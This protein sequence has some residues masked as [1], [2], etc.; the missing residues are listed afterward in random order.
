MRNEMPR[1]LDGN[2][3]ASKLHRASAM[4]AFELV[5]TGDDSVDRGLEACCVLPASVPLMP[6]PTLYD[7]RPIGMTR[8]TMT[9]RD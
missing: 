1:T 6:T 9:E 2:G 7:T 4:A 8:V 3:S 5:D